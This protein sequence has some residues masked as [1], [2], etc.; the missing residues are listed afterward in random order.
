MEGRPDSTA[1]AVAASLRKLIAS[2]E[3]G[4]GAR[5]VERD[6]AER[7]SVS[8]IP[9]REALQKLE[10]E[11][12]IEINRNRGAVVRTLTLD[13]VEEIYSLRMLL[14][15][16]AIFRAVKRI[17]AET[18]ARVELVHRLLGEAKSCDRQGELNREFHELLY[19]A[20]GNARMVKWI[21]ELRGQV[22]R[23]ERVQDVLLKDTD[24]F[25]VEHAAILQAC[26]ERN[27]RVAKAM[28]VEHLKSAKGVVVRVVERG[29]ALGDGVRFGRR[30][31]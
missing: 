21:R 22:E 25:Q 6:L 14:E 13:D 23:Y 27:A 29:R 10:A 4:D 3:V 5:L 18:L 28:T 8:R 20:C 2:G 12:L 17:D 26:L 30:R 31:R 9:M 11:G 19:A 15:G 24:A 1:D 7:F 16:D